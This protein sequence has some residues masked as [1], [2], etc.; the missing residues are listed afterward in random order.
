MSVHTGPLGLAS[1]PRAYPHTPASQAR[2]FDSELR[3][4]PGLT[5][6]LRSMFIESVADSILIS[7]V[8]TPEEVAVIGNELTTLVA[9]SLLHH[10]HLIGAI[11]AL[12]PRELWGPRGLVEKRPEFAGAKILGQDPWTH[13]DTLPFVVVEGAPARNEVV[14]FHPPS[15]TIYTA[16]LV[17]SIQRPQ[18]LLA[19]VA[20][21]ALGVYKRFGV[22]R[23]W[24][25]WIEDLP[26]FRRSIDKIL[27]WDFDRIA[28]AHGDLVNEGGKKKLILALQERNLL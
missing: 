13:E 4:L 21:R 7:P 20:L 22:A 3:M 17:F 23:M 25:R 28:M 6:P 15:R 5:I 2:Y 14:F 16:D 1:M 8:G 11:D 9:P 24:S 27:D 12:A 10:R 19:P 18:G 26:A